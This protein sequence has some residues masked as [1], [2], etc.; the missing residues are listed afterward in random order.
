[1]MTMECD[2][3]FDRRGHGAPKD[4]RVGKAPPAPVG[5]VPRISRLM[6]L[7]LRFDELIRSGQ[8][9]D[10]AELARIGGVSRAR[11]TQIMALTLLAPDIQEELLFLP[12]VERGRDG[13]KLSDLMLV[14]A[15]VGW[16]RQRDQ[17]NN[18]LPRLQS[19]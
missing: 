9:H 16:G 19:M 3:S 4:L 13:I 12:R 6:A 15:E 18:R 14:V 17:W 8:V 7:A 5:R 10:Y 11:I 1:M 2:V